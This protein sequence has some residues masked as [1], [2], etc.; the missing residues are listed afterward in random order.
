MTCQ[1]R[2]A[3][4]FIMGFPCQSTAHMVL[5][6]LS[7][8]SISIVDNP[9][10]IPKIYLLLMS[11]GGNPETFTSVVRSATRFVGI[12]KEKVMTQESLGMHIALRCRARST[13]IKSHSN[14]TRLVGKWHTR[15]TRRRRGSSLSDK[16]PGP[17]EVSVLA[18]ALESQLEL[19]DID[20]A[21]SLDGGTEE[22]SIFFQRCLR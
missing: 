16:E 9:C 22:M 17:E 12:G 13:T 1:A 6:A 11:S 21:P 14:F 19:E 3:G 20:K 7:S 4:Q 10:S 15:S 8:F 5:Y 18:K 2:H